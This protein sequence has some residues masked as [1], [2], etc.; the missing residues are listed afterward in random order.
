MASISFRDLNEKKKKEIK[1]FCSDQTSFILILHEFVCENF[2]FYP[3]LVGCLDR[4][5]N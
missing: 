1:T 2:D 5:S 3:L 4:K